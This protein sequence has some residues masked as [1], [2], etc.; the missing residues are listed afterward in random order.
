MKWVPFTMHIKIIPANP[1]KRFAYWRD[2]QKIANLAYDGLETLVPDTINIAQPGGGQHRSFGGTDRGGMSG[3][4]YGT[5]VKPQFGE[6]PAQLQITGFY[7]SSTA[8][9]QPHPELERIHAGEVLSG[10]G[11]HAWD[12]NPVSGVDN[13]VKALKTAIESAISS[14]LPGSVTF[15]VF[16]LEYA[17]II[18]GDRGYHFPL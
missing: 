11:A 13:E 5:A 9:I 7:K 3:L 2:M 14:A 4:A 12:A 17:G 15:T 10:P 6:S 8:N 1:N 16:R 18:Y